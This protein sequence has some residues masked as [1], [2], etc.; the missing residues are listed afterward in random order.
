MKAKELPFSMCF[1]I[2]LP[3]N[4]ELATSALIKSPVLKWTKLNS[5]RIL[6]HWVPLP[7]PGPPAT[8]TTNGG[9]VKSPSAASAFSCSSVISTMGFVSETSGAGA[10][11]TK[12][13]PSYQKGRMKSAPWKTQEHNEESLNIL[14]STF[15]ECMMYERQN[16][17]QWCRF[18]MVS[19][20]LRACEM[21]KKKPC[22]YIYSKRYTIKTLIDPS[23]PLSVQAANWWKSIKPALLIDSV[24]HVLLGAWRRIKHCRGLSTISCKRPSFPFIPAVYHMYSGLGLR[25]SD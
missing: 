21:F 19:W 4:D 3:K 9:V 11:T 23:S 25:P 14:N 1:S 7:H 17:G 6:A 15:H 24:L 22:I 8:K 18:L 2:S 16:L 20:S 12:G 5:S 10:S 13:M